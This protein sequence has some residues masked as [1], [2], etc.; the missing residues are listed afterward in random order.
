[1]G[2]SL[3]WWENLDGV[4]LSW[5]Q[6]NVAIEGFDHPHY[7]DSIDMDHDGDV[8]LFAAA[9]ISDELAWWE[10]DD[11]SGLAWIKHTIDTFDGASSMQVMDLDYDGDLDVLGS[12]LEADEFSWW[13]NSGDAVT[14]TKH[15]LNN[16]SEGAASVAAVDMDRDGDLDLVGAGFAAD[17]ILWWENRGGQF[18]LAT[19]DSSPTGMGAGEQAVLLTIE[20]IHNGRLGDSDLEIVALELRLEETVGDP[21][22]NAEANA[23][24]ESLEVYLDDGSGI[25]DSGIDTLIVLTDTLN[26]V[27]GLLAIPFADSDP[28]V[29][30]IFDMPQTYFVV[31][32]LTTDM[33]TNPARNGVEAFVVTHM[34]ESSSTA[35][36]RDFD[37]PLQMAYSPNVSATVSLFGPTAVSLKSINTPPSSSLLLLG[38]IFILSLVFSWGYWHK[39]ILAYGFQGKESRF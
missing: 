6:H 2:I 31:A 4:G 30:V 15:T 39:R 22:S 28:N 21:L 13:E 18:S 12:A 19:T 11:G 32:N 1:L 3:D 14:W 29:Q 38:I 37:I 17:N 34:T 9:S 35:E 24:I 20:V 10:N 16:S 33:E 27:N 25:F 7:V 26:L 36:D 8:D 23:I 5:L